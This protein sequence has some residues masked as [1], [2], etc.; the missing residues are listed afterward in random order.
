MLLLHYTP[1]LYSGKEYLLPPVPD[2]KDAP[3]YRKLDKLPPP[4]IADAMLSRLF[5][6]PYV[7]FRKGVESLSMRF[8]VPLIVS[9]NQLFLSPTVLLPPWFSSAFPSIA[10]YSVGVSALFATSSV[11]RS[12]TDIRKSLIATTVLHSC[13]SRLSVYFLPAVEF[14]PPVLAATLLLFLHDSANGSE[15]NKKPATVP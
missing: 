10:G 1:V 2:G 15:K 14:L 6:L 12:I 4:A 8:L 5:P 9:G 7:H 13:L 3:Y 11:L